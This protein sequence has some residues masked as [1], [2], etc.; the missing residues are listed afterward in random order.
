MW[1]RIELHKDGSVASAEQVDERLKDGRHVFYVESDSK[2]HACIN[3][4]RQYEAYKERQR[5]GK[6][7]A[8]AK[9]AA[10]GGC[11]E[12]GAPAN[13]RRRCEACLKRDREVRYLGAAPNTRGVVTPHVQEL[14]LQRA[15]RS[16]RAHILSEVLEVAMSMRA[17]I[18]FISWLRAER[19]AAENGK[20]AAE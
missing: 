15:G 9:R 20:V 17:G 18:A 8:R 10:A 5:L 13:G 11:T 14:R 16:Q 3:A 7:A 19:D 6:Q 1:F 4:L 2:E 12:C